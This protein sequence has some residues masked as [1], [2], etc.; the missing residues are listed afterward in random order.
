MATILSN[1]SRFANFFFTCRFLGKFSVKRLLISGGGS[2]QIPKTPPCYGL[3]PGRETASHMR[4]G[5]S[6]AGYERVH[7]SS[8]PPRCLANFQQRAALRQLRL[9]LY[10]YTPSVFL[11]KPDTILVVMSLSNLNPIFKIV[12]LAV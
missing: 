10:H 8:L 6:H 9:S 12:S 4:P 11:K 7:S 1:L 3:A 5:H 2:V